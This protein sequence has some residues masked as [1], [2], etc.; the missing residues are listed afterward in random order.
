MPARRGVLS[1]MV[2]R[3]GPGG[4]QQPVIQAGLAGASQCQAETVPPTRRG[5]G[6][7][8][9]LTLA[10]AQ[11]RGRPP[12]PHPWEGGQAGE[13]GPLGDLCPVACVAEPSPLPSLPSRPPPAA[14]GKACLCGPF[15]SL[16]PRPHTTPASARKR[17][18]SP[19]PPQPTAGASPP[20]VHGPSLRPSP[21]R[22]P[23]LPS[24]RPFQKHIAPGPVCPRPHGV[25]E[26]TLP[27]ELQAILLGH[28]ALTAPSDPSSPSRKPTHPPSI[29]TAW[30]QETRVKPW[31]PAP[32]HP[33][34]LHSASPRRPTGDEGGS[35]RVQ[36]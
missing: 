15:S 5:A 23:R 26:P 27:Q 11:G 8:R 32:R 1:G 10:A 7:A 2:G 18:P 34:D 20:S 3:Q 29:P 25:L 13:T 33:A 35:S 22:C 14:G 24:T 6:W 21:S 30:H 19:P 17:Q 36:G 12:P 31:V 28:S 4:L 9:A 16:L